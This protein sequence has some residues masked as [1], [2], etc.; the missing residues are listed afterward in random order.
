MGVLVA[1]E[2]GVLVGVR[3]GPGEGVRVGVTVDP[4]DVSMTSC[5]A[6]APSRLEK[7]MLVLLVVLKA[8]LYTALPVM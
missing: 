4:L 1:T 5:G 7:L 8:R 3:L 6:L 2:V